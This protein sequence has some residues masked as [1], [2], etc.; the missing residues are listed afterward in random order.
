VP[1]G[2]LHGQVAVPACRSWPIPGSAATTTN[3]SGATMKNTPEVI[4]SVQAG[5]L[6]DSPVIEVNSLRVDA[7]VSVQTPDRPGT[8]R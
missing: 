5:R 1:A 4:A 6:A 7:V 3:A 8:E 2:S